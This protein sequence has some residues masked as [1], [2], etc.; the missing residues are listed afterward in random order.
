MHCGKRIKKPR[1]C[2]V[3]SI[4]HNN[5]EQKAGKINRE[6]KKTRWNNIAE[7]V[8]I[9]KKWTVSLSEF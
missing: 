6:K 1:C 8:E 5:R 4:V 3:G 7:K 2:K 9:S